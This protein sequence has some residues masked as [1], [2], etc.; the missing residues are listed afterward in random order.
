LINGGW[1]RSA[2]EVVGTKGSRRVGEP[3]HAVPPVLP[4]EIA[5]QYLVGAAHKSDRNAPLTPREVIL[6]SYHS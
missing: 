4:E 2:E 1:R 5:R 3:R 6:F